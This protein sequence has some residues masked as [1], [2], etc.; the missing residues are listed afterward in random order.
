VY[1]PAFT[2]VREYR[3]LAKYASRSDS[4]HKEE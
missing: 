3:R 2:I 1:Y 4:R